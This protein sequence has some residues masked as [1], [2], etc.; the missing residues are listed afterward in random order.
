MQLCYIHYVYVLLFY[1]YKNI[2]SFHH[3][4]ASATAIVI[5]NCCC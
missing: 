1:V 3:T 5:I 4:E 2:I